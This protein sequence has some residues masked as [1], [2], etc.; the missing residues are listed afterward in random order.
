MTPPL[1]R[2][3]AMWINGGVN[4]AFDVHIMHNRKK[5]ECLLVG[6]VLTCFVL[7]NNKTSA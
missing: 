6:E 5:L 4:R 1:R 7:I 2:S 3:I